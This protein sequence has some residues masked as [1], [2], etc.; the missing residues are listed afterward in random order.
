MAWH[1]GSLGVPLVKQ[2]RKGYK[3]MAAAN[4]RGVPFTIH[5]ERAA[6]PMHYQQ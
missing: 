1:G 4:A 6:K 5:P 2:V 3:V